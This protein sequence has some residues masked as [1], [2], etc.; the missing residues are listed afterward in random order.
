MAGPDFVPFVSAL[1]L[2]MAP[3]AARIVRGRRPFWSVLVSTVLLLFAAAACGIGC[4]SQSNE[5]RDEGQPSQQN[6]QPAP[7]EHI[8]FQW[9]GGGRGLKKGAIEVSFTRVKSDDGVLVE[10]RTETYRSATRVQREIQEVISKA[11]SVVE[12]T[13]KL[14]LDGKPIGERAVLM[15]PASRAQ[16]A[17]AVVV[18]TDGPKLY[19]LE[20]SSLRHVLAFEKQLYPSP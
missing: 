3:G 12:R 8:N 18:W 4:R 9:A 20:S 16:E 6:S 10:W 11:A 14:S 15:V 19:V 7:A 13:T 1:R 2:R 5:A 17:Q